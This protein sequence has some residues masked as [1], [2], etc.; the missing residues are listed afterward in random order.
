MSALG[1]KRTSGLNYATSALSPEADM[2]R[3]RLDVRLCGSSI[4]SRFVFWAKF[5]A[6]GTFTFA[7]LLA[8]SR[9]PRHVRYSFAI[10]GKADVGG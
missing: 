6:P 1:Q 3:R 4:V 7:T 9:H 10:G 2:E 5:V 8:R